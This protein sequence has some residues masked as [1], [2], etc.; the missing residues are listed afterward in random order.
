[1][2]DLLIEEIPQELYQKLEE[3]ALK[4][5]RSII[6]E[7]VALLASA[8]DDSE[9]IQPDLPEPIASWFLPDDK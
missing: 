5:N 6:D 8:L 3:H 9:Q 1:M 2:P 4:N 7:V